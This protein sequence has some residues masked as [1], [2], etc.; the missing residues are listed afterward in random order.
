[1]KI[2]GIKEKLL[3]AISSAERAAGKNPTLPILSSIYLETS[4]N[5]LVIR[6]TNLDLGIE[7]TV[8]VKVIEGGVA[9][10][11]SGVLG[12]L[13]SNL[14]EE[15]ITLELV[16]ETLALST[17]S[18]ST[19]IRTLPADDFPIIPKEGAGKGVSLESEVFADALSSVLHS[20]AVTSMKPELGSIYVY[21]DGEEIV[22]AATD[23]FRLA[24]KR[25]PA[26]RA[27]GLGSALIPFRNVPEIIRFLSG[28]KGETLLSHEGNQ[29]SFTKD[30]A[31]LISR[32][33]EGTFP[34]YKQIV[35]KT[36]KTEATLL[37]E[38]LLRALKLAHVL[39]DT[40]NQVTFH[41]VP[42]EK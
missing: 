8:P 27:K 34:D 26:K 42:G 16:G 18:T 36:F 33:I 40:F 37:K 3:L 13:L 15:K 9:V 24:E 39:S 7:F 20:A 10:I 5:S 29:I 21:G 32:T 23:S 14:S 6:A 2:E 41:L 1:M 31:Y 19:V 38:D 17:K 30:G 25:I 28:S 4:T 11:P 35:P 22:F 12:S